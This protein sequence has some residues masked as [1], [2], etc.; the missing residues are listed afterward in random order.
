MKKRRAW[1]C[2]SLGQNRI[3]EWIRE[4]I[5]RAA[6]A[7]WCWPQDISLNF[8]SPKAKPIYQTAKNGTSTSKRSGINRRR[9]K[10]WLYNK[11]WGKEKK[12][13]KRIERRRRVKSEERGILNIDGLLLLKKPAA[14]NTRHRHTSRHAVASAQF[15][16]YYVYCR[17]LFRCCSYILV[18]FWGSDTSGT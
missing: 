17:P 8:F 7:A 12:K 4:W 10:T 18:F 3:D 16:Y 2:F 9:R 11:K 1:T 14:Q 6:A 15:F 13:K 5:K